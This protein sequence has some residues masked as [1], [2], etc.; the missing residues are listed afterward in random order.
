MS[1]R[2]A[3]TLVDEINRMLRKPAV[4]TETGGVG[5]GGTIVTPTGELLIKLYR[6]LE[7]R[8]RDAAADEFRAIDRLIRHQP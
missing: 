7:V 4:T 8:A 5:G 6:G 3:W 1:Y 2:R